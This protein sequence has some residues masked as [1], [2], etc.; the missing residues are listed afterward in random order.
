MSPLH[1][2]LALTLIGACG[3]KGPPMP[4]VSKPVPNA[5][6]PEKDDAQRKQP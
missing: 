2:L 1:L 6:Q 5:N 4:P 3:V